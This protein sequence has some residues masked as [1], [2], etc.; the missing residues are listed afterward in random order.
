MPVIVTFLRL[1]PFTVSCPSPS[2]EPTPPDWAHDPVLVI[3]GREI[4]ITRIVRSLRSQIQDMA[5]MIGV[6]DTQTGSW[7]TCLTSLCSSASLNAPV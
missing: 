1:H 4:E 2:G 3:S 5:N 7:Y 6:R